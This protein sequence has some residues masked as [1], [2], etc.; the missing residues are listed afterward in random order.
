MEKTPTMRAGFGPAGAS[1]PAP[2]HPASPRTAEPKKGLGTLTIGEH[3]RGTYLLN[4][5]EMKKARTGKDYL[6]L[7][8]SDPSGALAGNMFD[9]TADQYRSLQGL[10]VV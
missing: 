9:A 2:L 5:V 4:R 6:H 7:E 8:I 1:A 10:E 3:F